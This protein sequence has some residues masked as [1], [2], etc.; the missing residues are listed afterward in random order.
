MAETEHDAVLG[1]RLRTQRLTGPALPSAAEVVRLLTC[2]QSQER[3]QAMFSL[4]LRS[5]AGSV[6]AVRAEL[7]AG[8]VLRIHVLRPT[9]HFVL[10]EDL[11]WLLAVTSPRVE[12]SLRGRHRQLGLDGPGVVDR[13]LDEVGHLLAGGPLTR[14]EIG[15][16]LVRRGS[17]VSPGPPLGHLLL[18]GE[19]RGLVCS[20]PQKGTQHSY[21][22]V[23]D[24]VPPAGVA[25]VP[26]REEGVARLLRRFLSGHGP[27]SLRDFTRWSSLTLR[28]A[29][30][31]LAEIG[32]DLE[33]TRVDGTDL[34]S[35][36]ATSV[37]A[38]R[39]APDAFLLPTYDEAT[40][41]YPR[42]GF[43]LPAD[44]P[45]A[46]RPDP[47]WA[48]VIQGRRNVGVWKRTVTR[49]RVRV[50]I[51]LAPSLDQEAIE[52][53]GAAAGRLAD[54]LG[55]ELDLVVDRH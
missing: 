28:D 18:V 8:R 50:E 25:S 1:R 34:W 37:R 19:L 31:A 27:A 20:G 12:S 11:R 54:F 6:D 39:G 17:P 13:A 36:P 22:L 49:D 10:P 29:R 40:L 3:D 38:R 51:R 16:E 5:R 4:G 26:D 33:H 53:V 42:L 48:W 2:V 21:V 45:H 43:P 46:A 30:A 35:D 32:D 44:H 23:D 55:K 14:R 52:Q 15:D 24:A 47:F 7:D 9:W 41:T